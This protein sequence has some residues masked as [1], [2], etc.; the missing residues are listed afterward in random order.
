[1]SLA[2][3]GRTGSCLHL[4]KRPLSLHHSPLQAPIQLR[5]GLTLPHPPRRCGNA[6]ISTRSGLKGPG[7]ATE[8]HSQ[9]IDEQA[10][11]GLNNQSQKHKAT[12]REE[13]QRPSAES[14]EAATSERIRAP[15]D[16]NPPIT[17]P[18]E[19]ALKHSSRQKE[20]AAIHSHRIRELES[21]A[22]EYKATI[23]SVQEEARRLRQEKD[24]TNSLLTA[25]T[26]SVEEGSMKLNE[27][28]EKR[29]VMDRL[30][31]IRE[32]RASEQKTAI[33]SLQKHTR[34]QYQEIQNTK[35]DTHSLKQENQKLRHILSDR[36]KYRLLDSAFPMGSSDAPGKELPNDTAT[37]PSHPQ[38][39]FQNFIWLALDMHSQPLRPLRPRASSNSLLRHEQILHSNPAPLCLYCDGAKFSPETGAAA[40]CSNPRSIRMRSL[41][42]DST[43]GNAEL[44]GVVLALEMGARL[45]H[46][47]QRVFIFT[48]SYAHAS[49]T[50][51]RWWERPDTHTSTAPGDDTNGEVSEGVTAIERA[52]V[53]VETLKVQKRCDVQVWWLA[54]NDVVSESKA[55]HECARRGAMLGG[56][57]LLV[58]E[59]GL[60]SE[61]AGMCVAEGLE[62]AQYSEIG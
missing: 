53:A 17:N 52:Y 44:E 14:E 22:R 57:D 51:S 32:T 30:L 54:K 13:P 41:P 48:D 50:P 20:K 34:R 56:R 47:Q 8:T 28:K 29:S 4:A 19:E 24:E 10:L 49:S 36:D 15:D 37:L 40:V 26:A 6:T 55:A 58:D 35:L 1:M 16:L 7:L 46:P 27:E 3:H 45:A 11:L 18:Q 9:S 12:P 23:A 25:A 62:R 38:T 31:N 60:R 21:R 2:C 5:N 42:P 33:A 43:T 39:S 59:T 61:L